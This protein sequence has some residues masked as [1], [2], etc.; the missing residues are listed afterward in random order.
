V[1]VCSAIPSPRMTWSMA[2]PCSGSSAGSACSA[3]STSVTRVP[4]R[5]NAWASSSPTAPA[6]STT[7]DD[8]AS[9]AS[10]ASRL[11]Q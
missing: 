1:L 3:A 5:A 8:G 6:P 10:S 11:V 4:K 9:V 7:S 2:A